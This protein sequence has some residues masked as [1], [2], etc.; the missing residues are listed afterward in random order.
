MAAA[1]AGRLFQAHGPQVQLQ[2]PT[3]STTLFL[4]HSPVE[5]LLQC[6]GSCSLW[7]CA[8]RICVARLHTSYLGF[9]APSHSPGM[10]ASGAVQAGL[11]LEGAVDAF[12]LQEDALRFCLA[13]FDASC[14]H[15]LTLSSLPLGRPSVPVLLILQDTERLESGKAAALAAAGGLAGYLPFLLLG[16]SGASSAG[17]QGL[18]SLGA[19]V[20][21]CMLFGVT[22]RYAVRRDATNLHV[23]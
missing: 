17:L 12:P 8:H 3:Q 11:K 9:A 5:K 22:Y 14:C 6:V 4:S 21:A 19:S 7:V 2:G 1:L 13:A 18:L 16:S 10:P 23:S 20:A 15:F